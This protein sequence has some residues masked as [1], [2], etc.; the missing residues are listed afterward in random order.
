MSAST[1]EATDRRLFIGGQWTDAAEGGTFENRDP[2]TGDVV[3][4]VPAATRVDAERAVA[5]AAEA[6]PGWSQSL[7]AERQAMFLKAAD[8]LG[9]RRDEVVELLA[10]ESGSTFGFGMFQ[11]G[12]T[13][14]LLRQAAGAGYQ[15]VGEII[16]SDLPG[17]FAMGIRQ[18]VGVVG[19]VSPWNAALI[20]SLRA[21][22]APIAF[23]NTVVLKPSEW[24][25]ITGG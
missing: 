10:R 11:M 21:I 12:F 7:P 9:S 5:A 17:A 18:P 1:L 20:L 2:F 19:A 16:P 15:A 4:T 23:G 24:S 6:F 14:G 25:P 8:V 3:A 13:A 22:T